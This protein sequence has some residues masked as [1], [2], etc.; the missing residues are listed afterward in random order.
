MAV[1]ASSLEA[2]MF[3]RNNHL[4]MNINKLAERIAHE[5]LK[6]FSVPAT[7][8]FITGLEKRCRVI[9]DHSTTG[10]PGVWQSHVQDANVHIVLKVKDVGRPS[11]GDQITVRDNE[12]TVSNIVSDD[13]IIVKVAVR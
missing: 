8:R 3:L 6:A 2:F 9:V 7:Y 1:K 13:G 10:F 12:Y 5:A 11:Q 4:K